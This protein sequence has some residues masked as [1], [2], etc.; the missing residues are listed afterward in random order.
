[1][2]ILAL[3]LATKTGFAHTDGTS[4]VWVL[5]AGPNGQRWDDFR[6]WLDCM[7][8]EHGTDKIVAEASLHQPGLAGRMANAM[9]TMIEVVAQ[10]YQLEYKSV[11][12]STIKKHAT[13]N[14]RAKKPEMYEAAKARGLAFDVAS[15]DHVDALWILDYALTQL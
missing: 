6:E 13:G 8:S 9:H 15:D 10:K 7:V 4:G 1:M 5:P 14:G 12:A 3:D 11:A 2:R